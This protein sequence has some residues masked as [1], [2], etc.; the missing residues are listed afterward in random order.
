MSSRILRVE[1]KRS[2]APWAGAA[3]LATALAFM[4]LV[5]GENKLTTTGWT[6]QWTS[7][8]LQTREPL[9][10]LW[11]LAAGLGALQGLRDHRSR[12]SELLTSTPRPT[13]HR[14]AVLTAA[15]TITLASAFAALVLV[16]GVQVLANTGYTHLGWLPISL[17]GALTVVSGAVLGMGVGR[18]LPF[19]LTPP[20]VAVSLL[21]FTAFAQASLMKVDAK[22]GISTSEPNLFS[23]LSPAAQEARDVLLTL[24]ASVHVGQTIWLLGMAA[25]G[26]ALLAAAGPRSRLMAPAPALAGAVI[27]LLVL[28]SDP[29][30]VYVVDAAAARPVCDGPVCVTTTHR[31]WLKDVA[32]PARD[33]LRAMRAALG[34]QAPLSLH[35]DTTTGPD[36]P[37]AHRSRETAL[38]DFDDSAVAAARGEELTRALIANA[39]VPKCSAYADTISSSDV[40]AQSIA[41]SWVL[42][43]PRPHSGDMVYLSSVQRE[44]V[45]EVYEKLVRLPRAEQRARITTMYLGAVA[46]KGDPFAALGGGASR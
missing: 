1:L 37:R 22:T 33:A 5:T 7:M 6:G 12:A 34:D 2:I 9:F 32:G 24:S 17:V 10:F 3:V 40:K 26:F 39:L 28:P 18:T 43:E 45:R 16:G 8:A 23:L 11:P 15:M 35:E 41:V 30:Q 46:C 44:G 42:G 36:R 19:I 31:A 21:V 29:R 13:F 38:F 14:A 27:A 20:T 4:F 25:T